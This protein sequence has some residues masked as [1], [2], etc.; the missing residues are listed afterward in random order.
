MGTIRMEAG[1]RTIAARRPW[2]KLTRTRDLTGWAGPAAP[3][4]VSSGAQHSEMV[5]MTTSTGRAFAMLLALGAGNSADNAHDP[6]PASLGIARASPPR[7]P[8]A[9]DVVNVGQYFQLDAVLAPASLAAGASYRWH[10]GGPHVRDYEERAAQPW[11]VLP[12]QAVDYVRPSVSFYWLP[13]DSQGHPK[14]GQAIVRRVELEVRL[15]DGRR[16]AARADFR[17]ER[18]TSH[19]DLQAEDWYCE[20]NHPEPGVGM[21]PQRV[22]NE[23]ADWHE[24]HNW[25]LFFPPCGPQ[26]V[27]FRGFL[28][29]HRQQQARFD[30]W[31][32]LFGYPRH[33]T[34]D[35]ATPIPSGPAI[36]HAGRASSSINYPVPSYLTEAGG[37][38]PSECFRRTRLADFQSDAELSPDTFEPWHNGVHFNVG[39]DMAMHHTSPKDP[40]FWRLH[41]LID[42]DIY[43]RWLALRDGRQ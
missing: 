18:N 34:W 31:R 29:F 22:L 30:S 14:S 2:S 9:A 15:R 6:P 7:S 5:L 41:E 37:T 21:P 38:L 13:S 12:M 24:R 3:P 40:V 1:W 25:L 20:Y 11:R 8:Q 39:G 28:E 19:Q 33:E 16:L 43:G 35:P 42:R 27:G 32:V 23:H 10:V 26:I 4:S 36:D 17:V